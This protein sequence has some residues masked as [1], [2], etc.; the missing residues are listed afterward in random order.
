MRPSMDQ[1]RK[2]S[3]RSETVTTLP[4][5]TKCDL[6]TTCKPLQVIAKLV[7]IDMTP[8]YPESQNTLSQDEQGSLHLYGLAK[9]RSFVKTASKED[10]ERPFSLCEHWPRTQ[11]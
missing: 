11:R 10:L 7:N 6:K 3:P 5:N 1:C 8:E 2:S 9:C 4:R